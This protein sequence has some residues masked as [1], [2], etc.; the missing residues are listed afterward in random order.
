MGREVKRVPL[1]FDW[2]LEKTWEGYLS[3]YS[4][5][6]RECPFCNG[7]GLNR[8][9]SSGRYCECCGGDGGIWLTP[10]WKAK[11]DAWEPT[12]PPI[13]EG[14]QVWEIVSEGSPV[15]PV[16]ATKEALVD[17]LVS[18]GH[19]RSSSQAFADAGWAPSM[20]VAN[21]KCAH[22]VDTVELMN[23]CKAVQETGGM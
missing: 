6:W 9:T 19:M 16:F 11:D 23:Q 18:E 22:D 20:F 14:W 7:I 2:P 1:D 4:E 13:G 17:Y 15:S 12:D 8:I 10:E 3:P 21:G 5:Y